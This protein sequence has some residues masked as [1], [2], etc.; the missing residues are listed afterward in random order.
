MGFYPKEH[1]DALQ[2]GINLERLKN[3]PRVVT[4]DAI[5]EII[6]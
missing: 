6:L 4:K 2:S 5:R 3:N 1:M